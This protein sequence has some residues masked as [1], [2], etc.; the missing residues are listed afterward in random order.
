MFVEITRGRSFKGLAQYCLHDVGGKTA[1]RVA[2]V[3]TRNVATDNPQLA[4]RIMT[5]RYYLQDELKAKAGVGKGGPKDGK[6]VGHLLLSWKKEEAEAE[7]L[8][9]LSMLNAAN[10]ALRAIGASRHQALIIGHTD[11]PHPH[12]HIIINLIGEDGRLKK[13][14]N[15]KR[16]LSKFA[17]KRELEIHGEALVKQRQ[18][19]WLDRDAGESPAPV[20]KK[21]RHLYE[22]DKAAKKSPEIKAFAEQHQT[23]LQ[24]L[25][26]S[27]AAQKERHNAHQAKFKWCLNE[28]RRRTQSATE[29]KTRASRTAVRK[30]YHHSWLE[31]LNEQDAERRSFERNEQ[32]LKGS[33]ANAMQLIDWKRL[34]SRMQDPEQPG[35]MDAFQILTSEAARREKLKQQHQA[36]QDRLRGRQR[37]EEHTQE[38]AL[39]EEQ[40][41]LLRQ[42]RQAF[43]R[44]TAG[45]KRRQARS[46]QTLKE[47]QQSLTKERNEVLK[48]FR[49]QEQKF[50][51]QMLEQHQEQPP[52]S[53]EHD[54]QLAVSFQK[55]ADVSP[56]E[57]RR[58]RT[59]RP[60]KE[61]PPRPPRERTKTR[62]IDLLPQDEKVTD[63]ARQIDDFEKRMLEK[64]RERERQRDRGDRER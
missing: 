51:Q 35:L 22:L 59:R 58:S 16:K 14:W 8:N 57:G 4:W 7:Q 61:R 42:Q 24:E 23:T 52:S 33:L 45:M 6:P 2:F 31:L 10:A 20:K 3:Q 15:E 41:A 37:Q 30:A 26:R 9:Q 36:E 29:R 38:K 63:I 1:E 18:K 62:P 60:R 46:H 55:E 21:P 43:L 47:Q 12:C 17:L 28:R 39:Q 64:L 56:T 13:N 34:L 53:A 49:E 11:T 25:E 54:P 19:N 5:A 32:N 48:E 27:K 44:K 40:T 50:K